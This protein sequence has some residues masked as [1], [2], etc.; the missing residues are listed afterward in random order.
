MHTVQLPLMTTKQDSYEIDRRF[1]AISHIHNVLVKHVR[2]FLCRLSH[3]RG[4]QG[5]LSDYVLLRKKETEGK[6][7]L[8]KAEAKQKAALSKSMSERR[9][10]LD[11]TKKGLESYSKVCGRRYRKLVSSQQVQAEAARVWR[12]VE[13][14]LFKAG[15]QVHF[16]KSGVMTLESEDRSPS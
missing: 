7:G 15:G 6:D 9:K 4:Y 12:A 8:T 16:K 1:H 2:K 5:W 3:D 14:V 11:L 13:D 10:E